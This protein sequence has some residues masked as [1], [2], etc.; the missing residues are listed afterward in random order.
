[1]SY[2]KLNQA[3]LVPHTRSDNS[4]L[5][6]HSYNC[7]RNKKN[8]KAKHSEISSPGTKSSHYTEIQSNF[9][10]NCELQTDLAGFQPNHS[11][12]EYSH[13]KVLSFQWSVKRRPT[14]ENEKKSTK[15][16]ETKWINQIAGIETDSTF[17]DLI[18]LRNRS[19]QACNTERERERESD[20]ERERCWPWETEKMWKL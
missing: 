12:I 7:L 16:N 4:N 18:I 2:W 6:L 14:N 5:I 11:Q 19:L 9:K 13:Q 1:M 8:N 10:E 3:S 20:T 17:S 15:R